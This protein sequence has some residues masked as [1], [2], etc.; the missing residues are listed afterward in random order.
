[1]EMQPDTAVKDTIRA[2][3][4]KNYLFGRNTDLQDDDSFLEHGI[5]DSTGVLELVAFLEET[6]NIRVHDQD[7][8]TENLDSITKV[9]AFVQAKSASLSRA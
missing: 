7:M 1:M 3:I 8:S 9:E 4:V 6:F 2:F 5:I